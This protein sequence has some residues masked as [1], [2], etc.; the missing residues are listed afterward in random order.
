[1]I[2][3]PKAAVFNNRNTKQVFADLHVQLRRNDRSLIN[4]FGCRNE[5]E[6]AFLGRK[7]AMQMLI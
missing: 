6:L 5:H 2:E 3:R 7:I 1:L 4:R